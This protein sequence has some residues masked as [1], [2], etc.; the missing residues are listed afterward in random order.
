MDLC[1]SGNR[2]RYRTSVDSQGLSARCNEPVTADSAGAM[3][4]P[5]SWWRVRSS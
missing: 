4:Y 5:L 1:E 2:T 3:P